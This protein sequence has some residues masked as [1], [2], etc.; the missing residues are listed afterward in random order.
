MNLPP[1]WLL[2]K[3]QP[4]HAG[5]AFEDGVSKVHKILAG[6]GLNFLDAA[7]AARFYPID[8]YQV[9]RESVR[10]T[11]GQHFPVFE[12]EKVGKRGVAAH[13]VVDQLLERHQIVDQDFIGRL[14]NDLVREIFS[15][16]GGGRVQYLAVSVSAQE[17]NDEAAADDQTDNGQQQFP[18]KALKSRHDL[19]PGGA[20][21]QA[22]A[23][24]GHTV[25]RPA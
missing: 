12:N 6:F 21:G 24:W 25:V 22:C 14:K 13:V 2:R 19:P 18:L 17:G 10:E 15:V 7:F 5:L 11:V 4:Q 3:P 16:G 23:G 8:P 20:S 1:Q 9:D